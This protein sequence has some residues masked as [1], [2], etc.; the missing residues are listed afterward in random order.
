[1]PNF[2]TAL[3]QVRTSNANTKDMVKLGSKKRQTLGDISN[4]AVC[5]SVS[6]ASVDLSETAKCAEEASLS[7][8]EQALLKEKRQVEALMSKLGEQLK[9]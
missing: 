6:T 4:N 7:P 3:R 8:K 5:I 9:Q 2:E 1:M